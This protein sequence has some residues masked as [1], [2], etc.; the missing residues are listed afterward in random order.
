MMLSE[1]KII[2]SFVFLFLI[3]FLAHSQKTFLVVYPDPAYEYH[4]GAVFI[5]ES[6]EKSV[7]I[8]NQGEGLLRGSAVVKIEE[9]QGGEDTDVEEGVFQLISNYDFALAKGEQSTLKVRFSP[10]KEKIY[11]A[12]LIIGASDNQ[13]AELNLVGVGLKKQ[14]RYYLLGCGENRTIAYG[15]S[16]TVLDLIFIIALFVMLIR[17][18]FSKKTFVRL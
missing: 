6:I 17:K 13:N 18:T 11:R 1:S 7:V 15:I 9:G 8:T 5:G 14:K 3:G 4:F 10:K 16:D 12:K 2:S